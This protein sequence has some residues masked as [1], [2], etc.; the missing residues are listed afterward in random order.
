VGDARFR[1]PP[2]FDP[3]VITSGNV[4]IDNETNAE[5][6]L[7]SAAF[8][9]KRNAREEERER[10]GIPR[11]ERYAKSSFRNFASSD[12]IVSNFPFYLS[13]F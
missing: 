7:N 3:S 11:R 5:N 8:P 6:F 4:N 9:C 2:L 1:S 13:P 12:K 10:D